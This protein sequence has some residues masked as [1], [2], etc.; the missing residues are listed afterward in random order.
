MLCADK[1]GTPTENRMTVARKLRAGS[2][3]SSATLDIDYGERG[4]LPEA[5]H[6]LV[7]VHHSR[8][9]ARPVRSDGKGVS[10]PR[11]ALSPTPSTSV[12]RLDAGARA[13]GLTPRAA[14]DGTGVKARDGDDFVVAAKGAPEAMIFATS[15]RLRSSIASQVDSMASDGL[16][17]LAA[18]RAI[19]RHDGFA[20]ASR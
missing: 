3:A 15:A 18:A 8:Q 16:R 5:F 13:Y 17:V 2:E 20:V 4:E 11:R 10:P 6:A 12:S 9:R 7:E 1:T 19:S 14:G